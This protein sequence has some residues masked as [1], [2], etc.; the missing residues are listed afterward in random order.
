VTEKVGA[1]NRHLTI[2]GL[3]K[4]NTAPG[5]STADRLGDAGEAR[6]ASPV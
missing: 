3:L 1:I 6:S 5:D 4:G 2:E